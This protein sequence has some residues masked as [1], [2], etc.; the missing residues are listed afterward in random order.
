MAK[1]KNLLPSEIKVG[2]AVRAK[3]PNLIHLS[4]EA[5]QKEWARMDEETKEF[6]T[7]MIK[8]FGAPRGIWHE[9]VSK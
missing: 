9:I 1:I 2:A 3:T 7:D 4:D 5:K 6:I 8:A